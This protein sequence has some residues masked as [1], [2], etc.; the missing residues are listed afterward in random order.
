MFNYKSIVEGKGGISAKVVAMSVHNY[1][2]LLTTLELRYP[3][4]IHAEFMTHR[5]FSRNASSSR[6]IPVAKMIEQVRND[7]AMPIHWGKNQ[8]GMQAREEHDAEVWASRAGLVSNA[9]AW[10]CA[11]ESAVCAAFAFSEAGYHKQIVN[12]L[13]EPFQ[14]ITVIVTATEWDNFFKLR[15]HPDAQPEIQELAR[16][17]LEAMDK[18]PL[19]AVDLA[20]WHLPYIDM[21]TWGESLETAQMCS[22]ARC[23]RVSYL[24]HDNT[25]PNIDADVALH[26]RLKES[27]HMSPFEHAARPVDAE[28]SNRFYRNYRGWISYRVFVE[29]N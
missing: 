25:E 27:G 23:A 22:V 3:R 9:E 14:F 1:G 13:L 16:V 26:N 21:A 5:M 20:E 11:A 12:R 18:A 4:F 17:M 6:A 8:P 7:P 2:P 10:R 28:V 15:L 29:D 19:D 24:N